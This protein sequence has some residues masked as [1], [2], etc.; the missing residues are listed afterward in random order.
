MVCRYKLAAIK[1]VTPTKEHLE[2]HCNLF[3][4]Y[5]WGQILT[6]TDED[7]SSKPFFPGLIKCTNQSPPIAYKANSR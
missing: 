5:P 4:H 3:S 7:L 2:K 1:L 6:A